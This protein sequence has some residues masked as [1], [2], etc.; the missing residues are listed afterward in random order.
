MQHLERPSTMIVVVVTLILAGIVGLAIPLAS[1]SN[2]SSGQVAWKSPTPIPPTAPAPVATATEPAASAPTQ[3]T[4]LARTATA[5]PQ[6]PTATEPAK[7]TPSPAPT[8][9]ATTTE[10]ATSAATQLPQPTA[11]PKPRAAPTLPPGTPGTVSNAVVAV[12]L[13]N[14]RDGP[15]QG[16]G[17]IGLARSGETYTA[18]A[19]SGDG[20]W[21]KVC[22][23]GQAPAW[24]A[25]GMVT[26]SGRLESLPVAP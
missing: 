17:V 6:P 22:C 13:L 2:P 16:F 9:G 23:V 11:T 26:I 21:L 7:L 5:T 20:T 12:D 24:L 10:A 18:T 4:A 25:T 1:D 15:G 19:R 3:T 14:L 8:A